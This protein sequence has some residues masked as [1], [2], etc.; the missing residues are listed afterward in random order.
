MVDFTFGSGRKPVCWVYKGSIDYGKP[1]III[2]S[3][4][5][6]TNYFRKIAGRFEQML[7]EIGM[8]SLSSN[9]GRSSI[10]FRLPDEGM[11]WWNDRER[12][13]YKAKE[14]NPLLE[15]IF[16]EIKIAFDAGEF[17]DKKP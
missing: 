1:A 5:S 8:R 6:E 3:N 16:S 12:R 14:I 10:S 7:D 17:E 9:W 2:S 4:S 15:K 11:S 13:W